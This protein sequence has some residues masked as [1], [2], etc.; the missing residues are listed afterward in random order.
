M[1]YQNHI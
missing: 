1:V